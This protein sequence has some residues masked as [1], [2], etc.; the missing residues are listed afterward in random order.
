VGREGSGVIV[1]HLLENLDD[2]TEEKNI[3]VYSYIKESG[4]RYQQKYL[5]AV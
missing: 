2:E 1:R 4:M 5:V 3:Q